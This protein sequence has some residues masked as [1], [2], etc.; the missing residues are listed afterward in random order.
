MNE[1]YAILVFIAGLVCTAIAAWHAGQLTKHFRSDVPERYHEQGIP[2]GE[3]DLYVWFADL[4]TPQGRRIRR[5]MVL[6]AV[7]AAAGI[8]TGAR[9][10]IS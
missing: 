9:M 7:A 5:R 10:L 6:W 8:V 2:I 3:F 4:Y 1:R